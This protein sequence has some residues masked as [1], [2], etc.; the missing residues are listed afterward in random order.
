[1]FDDVAVWFRQTDTSSPAE[2]AEMAAVLSTDELGRRDRFR[3]EDDRRDFTAAHA[4]LRATLSR[5]GSRQPS[6]WRFATNAEGKPSL[7]PE[8]AAADP[9]TFNLSHTRGLVACVVARG[10]AVGI[11]VERGPRVKDVLAFASRYFSSGER[12]QLSSR[13]GTE[14]EQRFIEIWTLKE[15][16]LK[17]LGVGIRIPLDSFG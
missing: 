1:M 9:L 14:R 8:Q 13:H 15:A 3:F 7:A 2:I 11:D 5:Y 12:A 10:A 6:D 4:L 16:Y 17:A